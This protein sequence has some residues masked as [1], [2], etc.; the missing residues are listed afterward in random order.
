MPISPTQRDGP[1][2]FVDWDDDSGDPTY[3]TGDPG[4]W[5]YG[6]DGVHRISHMG[7]AYCPDL[8]CNAAMSVPFNYDGDDP[9]PAE[10]FQAVCWK[11][12]AQLRMEYEMAPAFSAR[13][14]PQGD[15]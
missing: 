7:D 13:L 3:H 10:V 5:T 11:C 1:K 14:A 8:D 12:G 2:G 9:R 6:E 15:T 4:Y